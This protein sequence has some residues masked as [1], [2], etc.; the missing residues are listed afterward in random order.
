MSRNVAYD[1]QTEDL[2]DLF[3]NAHNLRGLFGC[4][5]AHKVAATALEHIA[6]MHDTYV[7]KDTDYSAN[8]EPM[9]NMKE[10]VEMGIA[11]WRGVLLRIGDKKRR[12]ASFV[13]RAEYQ[14]K[15]EG[16]NDTLIDLANYSL[17]LAVLFAEENAGGDYGIRMVNDMCQQIAF[18]AVCG[19]ILYDLKFLRE[20]GVEIEP[21]NGKPW[22][23]LQV[24]YAA[25]STVSRVTSEGGDM[26][27]A[28]LT[29]RRD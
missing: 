24:S 26:V 17:L 14:V 6:G 7:R 27:D 18:Y 8:D 11:P 22:E 13:K 19:R 5:P 4:I 16:V 2:K 21:W 10:S 29:A 12:I 28:C 20:Y 15:D 23:W 25:L 1:K 9:G 3:S